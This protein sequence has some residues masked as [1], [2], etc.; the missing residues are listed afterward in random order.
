MGNFNLK[1]GIFRCKNCYSICRITISPSY[2][3]S[4]V[5]L[6]CK[7]SESRT[8]IKNFLNELTKG[9]KMKIICY[10]CQK[11]D[12]KNSSYC[13]DC[14][15]IYC[16][17]CIK[18]YHI[19]HKYISLTKSDFYCISHQKEVFTN[20]C[21]DCEKNLCPKCLETKR[22]MYH[23]VV[24]FEKIMMKKNERDFLKQKYNLVEEKFMFNNSL[25]TSIV[26][27][28]KNKEDAE[29]IINLEKEN[30]EQNKLILELIKF[31][32]H[33]YDTSKL[34]NYYIII[35]FID[36][37]NLNV[38]KMKLWDTNIKIEN[39]IKKLEKYFKKDFIIVTNDEKEDELEE[40]NNDS[41]NVN[42][43]IN[44]TQN[45]KEKNNNLSNLNYNKTVNEKNITKNKGKEVIDK[46]E[47]KTLKTNTITSKKNKNI[48]YLNII[49]KIMKLQ[50]LLKQQKKTLKKK[51][52]KILK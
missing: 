38:N 22:H 17:K 43:K 48:K 28:M 29:K 47:E 9:P 30:T 14:N 1:S 35:N 31:F 11:K 7:C 45:E 2:P 37:I 18:K 19:N 49:I 27:K 21:K 20:F 3:E 26:K 23:E 50:Y 41:T 34:K 40:N 6:H 46:N 15:H 5:N 33:L 13:D 32:T 36:N 39:V 44:N 10:T 16:N 12:D 42:E 24:D 52:R 51:K 25:V 4:Y 8:S